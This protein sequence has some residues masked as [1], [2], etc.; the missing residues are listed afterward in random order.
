MNDTVEQALDQVIAAIEQ[1]ANPLTVPDNVK[2]MLRKK[3]RPDFEANTDHWPEDKEKVLALAGIVGNLATFL[4]K[5]RGNLN[6]TPPLKEVQKD[7]TD[8]AAWLVSRTICPPPGSQPIRGRHCK[9]YKYGEYPKP[10]QVESSQSDRVLEMGADVVRAV[11]KT[12][13]PAPCAGPLHPT[14]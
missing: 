12:V 9:S 6:Q 1:G 10:A 11:L 4:T 7:C 14:K 8:F 13:L 3:Y 2:T 5:A